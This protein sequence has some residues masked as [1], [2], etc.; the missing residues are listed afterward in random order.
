MWRF[1]NILAVTILVASAG[2]AYSIKYETILFAEQIIKAKHQIADQQDAIARLHAEW[3]LL[4][5]P[6]R[7][8]ALAEQHTNLRMLSLDQIVQLSELPDRPPKVDT[9]GRKL[10][11]LGLAEP[12]N[13]PQDR[14]AGGSVATPSSAR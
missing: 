6:E 11:S 8:Q 9:I 2:Y 13:T 10:D 7:L 14:R 5:R 3:A 1:V 4:T 12:T